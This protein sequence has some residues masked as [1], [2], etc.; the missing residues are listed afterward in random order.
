MDIQQIREKPTFRGKGVGL[1]PTLDEVFTRFPKQSFLIHIKSD[2]PKEGEL[3]A[4]YLSKLP[5]H[6]LKNLAVYGGDKPI[7]TLKEKLPELCVLCQWL[8]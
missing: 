8:H 3:L 4:E 5:D 6:R 7:A 1:M 2:N